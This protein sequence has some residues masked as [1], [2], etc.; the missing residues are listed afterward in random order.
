MKDKPCTPKSL[1][2]EGNTK[3]TKHKKAVASCLATAF[4]KLCEPISKI[5]IVLRIASGIRR[6]HYW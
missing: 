4:K 3:H 1:S 6:L 2:L 5:G